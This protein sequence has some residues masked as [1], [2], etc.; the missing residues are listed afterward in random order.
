MHRA[1]WWAVTRWN[2]L[3]LLQTRLLPA[4]AC[5]VAPVPPIFLEELRATYEAGK[6][7]FFGNLAELAAPAAFNRKLAEVRRLE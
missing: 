1:G 5:P 7:S 4:G 6:L 3:D 2:A